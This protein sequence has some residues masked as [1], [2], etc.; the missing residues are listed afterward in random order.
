MIMVGRGI[1][2]KGS[3]DMFFFPPLGTPVCGAVKIAPEHAISLWV[4]S[5]ALLAGDNRSIRI[6][7]QCEEGRRVEFMDLHLPG[8]SFNP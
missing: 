6:D 2:Y 8:K 7:S 1:S 3:E 4:L 5:C